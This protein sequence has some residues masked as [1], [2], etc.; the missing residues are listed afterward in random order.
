MESVYSVFLPTHTFRTY[1]QRNENFSDD[2]TSV[3]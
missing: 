2:L 3:E 1:S